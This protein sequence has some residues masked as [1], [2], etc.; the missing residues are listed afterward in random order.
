MAA[1]AC[2]SRIFAVE[3]RV[4]VTNALFFSN[5]WGRNT[6]IYEYCIKHQKG[7]RPKFF[8]LI[9]EIGHVLKYIFY[10]RFNAYIS[11][12]VVVIDTV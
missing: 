10:K 2:T 1:Q 6:K 5:L 12:I 4:P 8:S 9:L 7:M 11:I 3:Y